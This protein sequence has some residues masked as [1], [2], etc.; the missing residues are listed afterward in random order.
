MGELQL[1]T[2]VGE[3]EGHAQWGVVPWS[4][5]GVG[6]VEEHSI[7][8]QQGLH[9]S[10]QALPHAHQLGVSTKVEFHQLLRQPQGYSARVQTGIKR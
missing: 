1:L 9:L 8:P 10:L 2:C 4:Y 7:W 6:W 3:V 5:G